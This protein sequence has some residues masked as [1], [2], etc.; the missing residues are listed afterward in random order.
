M[1]T[2]NI[3]RLLGDASHLLSFFVMFWKLFTSQSVAGISMKTQE[4]YGACCTSVLRSV[5][6]PVSRPRHAALSHR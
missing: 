5:Q 2:L 4:I 3:F 6:P 1:L